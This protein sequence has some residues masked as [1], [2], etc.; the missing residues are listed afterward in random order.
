MLTDRIIYQL[1]GESTWGTPVTPTVQ[2]MG[3]TG[4]DIA[5]KLDAEVEDEMNGR[6]GPSGTAVVMGHEGSANITGHALYEDINYPLESMFGTVAP[7]G[8]GP[9]TRTGAAPLIN[10]TPTSPRIF[11]LYKGDST[12]GK[13]LEG[14][15][16]NELT[17]TGNSK[18]YL[19]YS[20]SLIGQAVSD[21]TPAALSQRTVNKILGSQAALAVD[22][23]GGTMGG[24]AQATTFFAYELKLGSPRQL[25][26]YLGGFVPAEWNEQ[27][28]VG[29]LKLDAKY[30]A[31]AI[32]SLITDILSV[33]SATPAQRQIRITH[34]NT[35]NLDLRLD[36]AGSVVEGPKFFENRNGLVTISLLMTATFNSTFGNWFGYRTINSVSALP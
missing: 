25:Q 30:D 24:T 32:T 34:A 29:T 19:D 14:G 10:T 12:S 9:Y 35:A 3:V 18:G 4:G 7:S 36:F 13:R 33:S 20:Y 1:G 17:L 5:V 21:G 15:L 23:W 26:T 6:L 28:V 31:S 16:V 11:T 8:A 22:S 27:K 2:L